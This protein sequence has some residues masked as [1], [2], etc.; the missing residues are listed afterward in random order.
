MK[1]NLEIFAKISSEAHSMV[2]KS[3]TERSYQAGHTVLFQND[4][5]QSVYFI[6][7]G[8][9]KVRM[10]HTE[11]HEI[12]LNILG[13]DEIVGEM[14]ALDLS[15]RSTDVLA[16]TAMRLG[17][18]PREVFMH[19]LQHEP[20]FAQEL[21]MLMARRLRQANRRLMT[22]ESK[23]EGRLVD[24]LLFIAEGQGRTSRDGIMIPSFPHRELAALSGL[25]RE[26]VT[27]ILSD[28]Q[29]RGLLEKHGNLM[30]IPSLDH[31][32]KLLGF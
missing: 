27:R 20:S 22:R 12:T 29:R 23:G 21:L 32:E 26:T 28:L 6:L 25:A 30:R 9:A 8:W 3:M 5:G 16:L 11:G 10:F 14:A 2:A 18:L 17:L 19:L 24:T 7:E 1:Y 15:P 4:W 31:L 13:P